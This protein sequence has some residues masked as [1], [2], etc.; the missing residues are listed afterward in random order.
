MTD[1]RIIS[2]AA[3][4]VLEKAVYDKENPQNNDPDSNEPKKGNSQKIGTE[5]KVIN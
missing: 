2:A 4:Y 5:R 3:A 1:P